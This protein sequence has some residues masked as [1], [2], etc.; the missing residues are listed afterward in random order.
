MFL[1]LNTLGLLVTSAQQ[2]S[3]MTSSLV[4]FTLCWT[5][6]NKDQPIIAVD[7]KP[8]VPMVIP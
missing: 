5:D 8:L 6:Q 2:A 1:Q 7:T 3:L 4:K